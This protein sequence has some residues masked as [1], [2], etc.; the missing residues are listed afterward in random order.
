VYCL[1]EALSFSFGEFLELS[2]HYNRVIRLWIT[3][4]DRRGN[5]PKKKSFEDVMKIAKLSGSLGVSFNDPI[6]DDE[7]D[8]LFGCSIF[9]FPTI[10][11]R[12]S[13]LETGSGITAT[14]N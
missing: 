10:T 11:M 13:I 1:G 6:D 4:V 7:A 12:N 5:T 2:I 3:V 14:G 9:N 8:L